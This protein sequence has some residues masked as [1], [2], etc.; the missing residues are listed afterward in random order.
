MSAKQLITLPKK[1][2]LEKCILTITFFSESDHRDKTSK[3]CGFHAAGLMQKWDF[4]LIKYSNFICWT[5]LLYTK[6]ESDRKSFYVLYKGK[7]KFK[8]D[9]I[10]ITAKNMSVNMRS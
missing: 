7:K 1:N 6:K 8:F 10:T 4:L 5:P 2:W 9:V 3:F